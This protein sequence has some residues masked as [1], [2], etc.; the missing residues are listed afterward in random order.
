MLSAGSV[1][2]AADF[3]AVAHG[4]TLASRVPFVHFFDGFRTS[5]EVNTIDLLTD[6]DLRTL[7]DDEP[8]FCPKPGCVL[9]GTRSY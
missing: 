6:E 2:E 4:A 3:A 7:I 9:S 5:H 1:Q 8:M